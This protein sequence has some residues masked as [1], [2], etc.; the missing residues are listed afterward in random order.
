[1]V[2]M[3]RKQTNRILQDLKKKM[4]FLTG[5]RQVGKTWLAHEIAKSY[6]NSLYLT[7]DRREDRKIM[8]TEAWLS[9]IDLLI[10]D[11]LHKMPQWK[12]YL[13]GIYDTKSERLSI[14]VIGSA[15]LETFRQN[16]DSLAGR[17]FRHRLLPFTPSEVDPSLVTE[18]LNRFMIRGGFPEPF[19]AEDPQDADRWRLQYIDGLIRNDIL[20]FEKIHDLKAIQLVFDLLRQRVGSPISFTSLARDVGI[21]PN[22]V[23][24]HIQVFEA[25]FIIFRVVPYSKNIARSILKEPKI[26]F[27]DTGLVDAEIG[28]KYENMVAVSLLKYVYGLEDEEG[29]PY[30]LHY[31][32]TKEGREVDFCITHNN[33]AQLM[34][35]TKYADLSLSKALV[36]FHQKYHIPGIQLLSTLKH[37]KKEQA[38]EIRQASKYLFLLKY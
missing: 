12:N 25:L 19:L 33:V 8:E 3:E 20:D 31:L 36:Q 16:G 1:M 14:L 18:D 11:E 13:K 2:S 6:S 22:T 9:D 29:K 38:I 27:Y 23:K 30:H 37:E 7:Y 15:L 4:V 10:L 26:Y 28:I 21:S 35:E 17:F 24:K 32:R 5:P 34:I